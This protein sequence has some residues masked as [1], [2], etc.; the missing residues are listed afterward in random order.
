MLRRRT[1]LAA[2]LLLTPAPLPAQVAAG[3]GVAT[4]G[5]VGAAEPYRAEIARIAADPGVVEAFRIIEALEG[6]SIADLIRLTEIPAPPFMESERAAA[7]AAMLRSAGADSVWID[8]AGNVLA[9]RR[10]LRGDR[11]VALDG[12]LDTVF[13]PDVDVTVRLRGDT[14]FAPGIGDDTRGLIV[15][16]NVL[17]AMVDAGLRTRADLLFIGSVG[18]EGLG[19][20]RG[21]KHLFEAGAGSRDIDAFISVD[22][23]DE[24]R[25]KVQ[26]VGS[27]RYRVTFRG[28][29]G[30]SWGAFGLA[31]PHHGL[32][33]AGT[34]FAEAAGVFI[35][36]APA[37]TTFSIGRIGGGTSV[38]SIPYESWMEVDMR[39]LDPRA[40]DGIDAV[41]QAAVRH[42]LQAE[43]RARRHGP[44]LTAAVDRVGLRPAAETPLE[45]PLIQRAL[46]A[47]AH[48]G[49]QPAL[50]SGSTN[51]NVPMAMGIPA[52]TIGR[53]GLGGGA[54]S[55]DEWW[56]P[57]RPELAVQKALL[58]VL[59]EAGFDG[60]GGS[61]TPP[62]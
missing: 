17:R 3:A 33:R 38:N 1:L 40:L 47:T 10:G 9:L 55:L 31:N 24:R 22:G 8:G 61:D 59:A 13:P 36:R 23:G 42:G 35:E 51:A 2:L 18:E 46:A 60:R 19:D 5:G 53:G 37:R 6:P 29:G 52:T 20:L 49:L 58:I 28:P 26:A 48:L 56:L 44:A 39:S 43:N 30:H 57:Q 4:P 45:T 25:V 54:H 11:T 16:R 21:V 32:A 14:L 41:F 50:G 34:R 62:G 15:V 7:F 27:Y 12:H